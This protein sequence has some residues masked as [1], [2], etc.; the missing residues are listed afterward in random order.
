MAKLITKNDYARFIR[1][2]SFDYSYGRGNFNK[3]FS[4]GFIRVF[5]EC[6][7]LITKEDVERIQYLSKNDG[8]AAA[9]EYIELNLVEEGKSN[10]KAE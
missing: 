2:A 8:E 5:Y 7:K 10:V 4:K 3:C 9:R 1:S 6:R